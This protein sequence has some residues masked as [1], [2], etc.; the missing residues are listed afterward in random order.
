MIWGGVLDRQIKWA[1]S[2]DMAVMC[3]R[4]SVCYKAVASSSEIS[5]WRFFYATFS[6]QVALSWNLELPEWL[7]TRVI[8]AAL[9][10]L[11]WLIKGALTLLC[12][13]AR[14]EGLVSKSEL[15]SHFDPQSI[16]SLELTFRFVYPTVN[17]SDRS[18]YRLLPKQQRFGDCCAFSKGPVPV[19]PPIRELTGTVYSQYKANHPHSSLIT[20][21]GPIR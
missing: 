18:F 20:T 16:V 9:P 12:H 1:N 11:I 13:V 8:R 6:Y 19:E 2:E 17:K 14:F 7:M 15:N 10:L 4:H 21:V 5:M 3:C